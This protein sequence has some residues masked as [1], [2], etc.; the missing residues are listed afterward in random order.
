MTVTATPIKPLNP[1]KTSNSTNPAPSP[2]WITEIH[3]Q[4][5]AMDQS[6]RSLIQQHPLPLAVVAVGLG[7][8]GS[9]FIRNMNS[10]KVNS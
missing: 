7:M 8:I 4:A 2:D 1:G 3:S 6:I 10:R 9:F 5:T